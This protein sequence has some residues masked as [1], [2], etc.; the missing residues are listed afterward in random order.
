MKKLLLALAVL[1]AWIFTSAAALPY[2]TLRQTMSNDVATLAREIAESVGGPTNGLN[3]AAVSA[4]I[5]SGTNN[6]KGTATTTNRIGYFGGTD[7]TATNRE[8][9]WAG[10]FGSGYVLYD[11]LGNPIMTVFPKVPGGGGYIYYFGSRTNQAMTWEM[12]VDPFDGNQP[13]GVINFN[14]VNGTLARQWGF[15]TNS[16][17]YWSTNG[18]GNAYWL[19]VSDGNALTYGSLTNGT[20]IQG[21]SIAAT[22]GT[23]TV[24]VGAA[25]ISLAGDLPFGQWLAWT[26]AFSA[27]PAQTPG[28]ITA[29]STFNGSQ[30]TAGSAGRMTNSLAGSY[31]AR[32]RVDITSD[33]VTPT[34]Y[35][36][37]AYTNNVIVTNSIYAHKVVAAGE[38]FAVSKELRLWLP[39][40]TWLEWRVWTFDEVTEGTI[41]RNTQIVFEQ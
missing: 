38:R 32:L 41:F 5:S 16:A 4:A 14:D 13:R 36:F 1:L 27:T 2:L 11:P 31:R 20:T 39:A 15:Y 34:T 21:S 24:N 6:F 23:N 25:G 28:L 29:A 9:Y 40:S 12:A 3:A 7:T 22:A 17:Y 37:A 30:F 35:F 33:D 19:R 18:L 26:N 10:S 8:P